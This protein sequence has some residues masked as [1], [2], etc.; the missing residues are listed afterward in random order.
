[1]CWCGSVW[2][3]LIW[4]PVWFLY[5]CIYFLL[6][7]WEFS[8]II[9]SNTFLIFLSLSSPSGTHI[10]QIFGCLMLSQ[11]YLQLL[12]YFFLICFSYCCSD[13][14]V[15]IF[16]TSRSFTCSSVLLCLLFIP[17]SVSFISAIE[18]FI[19]DWVFLMFSSSLLKCSRLYQ[20]FSLIQ[21]TFLLSMF[22]II[23]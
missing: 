13:C 17:S 23:S 21:L 4:D 7:V 6:Q 5:L 18:L 12:Y 10:M 15:S 16:L 1:M 8:G 9:S 19:S 14:V 20:L 22:W 3:Y 11:E 2:V